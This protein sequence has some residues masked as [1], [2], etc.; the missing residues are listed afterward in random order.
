MREF[1]TTGMLVFS[2]LFGIVVFT[3]LI[4][5]LGE[6]VSGYLAVDAVA[7]MLGFSAVTSLPIILSIS[8]FL[9]VLMT[10][11][12][13]YRD[14]EMVVWFSAG[15]GLTRWIRP[16]MGYA[17]VVSVV[18]ATFSLGITPWALS[19]ADE[20]K[21][22][23][24]SRDDVSSATPGVFRESKQDDRVFFME[25]V[26]AEKRRVGN[27]FV[28]S[29]QNGV[30]G[31]MVAK[32]GFQETRENGERYLIMLNGTRYEGV[33][34]QADFKIAEFERYSMRIEPQELRES[35]PSLKALS[36]LYLMQNPSSFNRAELAWRIGLPVSA[37][38]LALM[39][40]PLSFVDPRAG[41]SLNF[42]SAVVVFM[43]YN[44]LINL[45]HSWVG[46]ERIG[47][48]LGFWGL[49]LLMLVLLALLFYHRSSVFAWAR[50]K[51]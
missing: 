44:N 40:I 48:W 9:S 21:R 13:C 16:V 6:S 36:S 18:I 2:I 8:L 26:D 10:L 38:V 1:V 23:L 33:P 50:W 22:R 42:I 47:L 39:A 51:R 24:S 46:R 12:R 41:R 4:R 15:I 49:H 29:V 43:L 3:Q 31:T 27:I 32:E 35:A 14:S 7:V 28:Q 19:Q 37:I 20:F 11:T 45:S 5:F 34:G 30:T 17:I 25:N